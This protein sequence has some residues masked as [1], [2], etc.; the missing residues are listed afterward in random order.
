VDGADYVVCLSTLLQAFT[1]ISAKVA[2][3]DRGQFCS[4]SLLVPSRL[5]Q[6]NS[7]V[8]SFSPEQAG[9]G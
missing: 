4:K 8:K 7:V 6:A 3:D 2:I 5:G 9:T 1:N